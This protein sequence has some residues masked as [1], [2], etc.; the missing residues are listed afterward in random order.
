M[1]IA[2]IAEFKPA[3]LD[4][5]FVVVKASLDLATRAPCVQRFEGPVQ[6]SGS[7][8]DAHETATASPSAN[9]KGAGE[10]EMFGSVDGC[11][12]RSFSRTTLKPMSATATFSGHFA[13]ESVSYG[14]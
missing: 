12:T 4:I 13:S 11:L 8:E 6:S 5:S 2:P 7:F 3:C 9:L 10:F 1:V 14:P